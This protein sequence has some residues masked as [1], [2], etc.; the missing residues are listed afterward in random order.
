MIANPG[1]PFTCVCTGFATGLAGTIG[2]TLLD[3]NGSTVT[4]RRTAGITEITNITGAYKTTVIAPGTPALYLV[5]WDDGVNH[6]YED[7]VVTRLNAR[8]A[9]E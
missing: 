1:D 3:A 5:D 7:V 2:V 4:A 6:A 8:S 9:G